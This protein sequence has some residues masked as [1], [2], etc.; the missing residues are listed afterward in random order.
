MGFDVTLNIF[1]DHITRV[2]FHI[3][4]DITADYIPIH[5]FDSLRVAINMNFTTGCFD[6]FNIA[7]YSDDNRGRTKIFVLF[8]AINGDNPV[9]NGNTATFISLVIYRNTS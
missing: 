8:N 3:T 5:G 6:F 4:Q 1:A 9:C 2:G 7:I